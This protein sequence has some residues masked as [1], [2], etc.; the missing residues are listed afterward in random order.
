MRTGTSFGLASR[1]GVAAFA[2]AAWSCSNPAGLEHA[3]DVGSV[4]I[5]PPVSTVIV[6]SSTPLKA[7]VQDLTGSLLPDASV[8]WTV[9]DPQVATVSSSG[10]VSALAV[11]STQV[12]ASS[13][14]RSGLATI[15]VQRPPVANVVVHPAQV[16]ALAGAHA[17]LSAAAYDAGNT[18][19]ADRQIAWS[20]S[21]ER[22]ATVDGTG[23]V[24]AIAAGTATISATSEAKSGTATVTVNEGPVASVT[25][26][27]G[28]VAMVVGQTAPLAVATHNASGAT[29]TGRAV[30]WSSSSTTVASVDANGLVTAV[31]AGSTTITAT[32]EGVA[33]TAALTVANVPV[34]SVRLDAST[35]ALNVGAT[36]PVQATVLDANGTV[37]TDRTVTWSS[38]NA[39]VATVS[40]TGVVTG[41]AA[42]TATV[43]ATAEGKT[44]SVSV[45]V[46]PP[47]V[48]T[49]TVS[50]ASK[51]L[52]VGQTTVLAVTVK[53]AS[54]ATL[55]DRTVVWST[56]NG[57]VASVSQAGVV[58]AL[59][60]GTVT[61]TATSGGKSGASAITVAAP[62]PA[63]VASVAVQPS[64]VTLT[65]TDN[66]TASL[67]TILKD[68]A[69]NVLTGRT[70][71][72]TS[73]LDAIATVSSTGIVTG[74][75]PGTAIITAT[76]EGK[77]GTATVVVQTG[78][79]ASVAVTPSPVSI[80]LG[81]SVQLTATAFDALGNWI[82]GRPFTWTTS[83]GA[84]A[85]VTSSGVVTAKR[86]GTATITATLDGKS[87]STT[88]N[89][90]QEE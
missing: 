52:T 63:P 27:P 11:G 12:A 51:S 49:V 30:V 38:S 65:V 82:T 22:V 2:L 64:S 85:T 59:A 24:T 50:P 32:S 67:T 8:I 89:V 62:P 35:L 26:I 4:S 68:A 71:T 54:G 77:T 40:S 61:I 19:L 9:K 37:V 70:V 58:T 18:V 56:S 69:G 46:S 41:V 74:R 13:G 28:T 83:S 20:S 45:T 1:C 78:P 47:P 43:T 44:A 75:S 7:T 73:S 60:A 14:G 55:T 80:R 81:N 23:L 17:Q 87:G 3:A 88:V 6:G 10:V 39:L 42:G 79:A 5:D 25:V 16:E 34:G 84:T 86:T 33:G 31:H 48:G 36:A 29:V 66:P 72:W 90:S 57:A 53:D 21:N 76:S 15:T